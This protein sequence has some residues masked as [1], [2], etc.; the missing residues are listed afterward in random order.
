MGH[1]HLDA[2]GGSLC[3]AGFPAHAASILGSQMD[4][5]IVR[6][7]GPLT[8]AVQASGAKNSALKLLAAAL[9]APGR[10][11]I[12]NVPDIADM[13]VMGAVLEHLGVGVRREAKSMFLE[14]PD[15]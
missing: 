3:L 7:G 1:G 6:G 4:A 13:R 8:G 12:S 10:F 2:S 11:A 15:E 9:L 5:F 14:V